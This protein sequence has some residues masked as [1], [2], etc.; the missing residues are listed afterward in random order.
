MHNVRSVSHLALPAIKAVVSV[1]LLELMG[2]VSHL[3]ASVRQDIIL[4]C[5]ALAIVEVLYFFKNLS[6]DDCIKQEL[7]FYSIYY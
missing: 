6:I 7:Y 4:C 1:A 3:P 5:L 2:N